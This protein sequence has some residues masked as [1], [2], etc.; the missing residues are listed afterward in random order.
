MREATEDPVT[1]GLINDID[2]VDL[3][4]GSMNG[5]SMI[6]GMKSVRLK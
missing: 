2:D 6:Y 5:K 4:F 3:G 1:S